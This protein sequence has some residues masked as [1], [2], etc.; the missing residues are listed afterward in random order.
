M[1]LLNLPL[2]LLE[3]TTGYNFRSKQHAQILYD[4]LS[5]HAAYKWNFTDYFRAFPPN[6][7][8][9]WTSSQCRYVEDALNSGWVSVTALAGP[10]NGDSSIPERIS[11]RPPRSATP[12]ENPFPPSHQ[13]PPPIP[14]APNA[15]S[16]QI[17]TQPE[18]PIPTFLAALNRD[19]TSAYDRTITSVTTTL[20]A[21]ASTQQSFLS[22][23]VE[24]L[25]AELASQ[26]SKDHSEISS[27]KVKV[28]AG[29]SHGAREAE[30][31]QARAEGDVAGR[32]RAM[33]EIGDMKEKL[34]REYLEELVRVRRDARM[35]GYEAGFR[36][37]VERRE[38]SHGGI[39][40]TEMG[41]GVARLGSLFS[42]QETKI[43]RQG[44]EYN[45]EAGFGYQGHPGII[46]GR[47]PVSSGENRDPAAEMEDQDLGAGEYNAEFDIQYQPYLGMVE[48]QRPEWSELKHTHDADEELYD[49]TPPRAFKQPKFEKPG[50]MPGSMGAERKVRGTVNNKILHKGPS[51][52]LAQSFTGGLFLS[53]DEEIDDGMRE[54]PLMGVESRFSFY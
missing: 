9:K 16:R 34:Q 35:E 14:T 45:P 52:G 8:S 26:R 10:R 48:E 19:L 25:S 47:R 46:G 29:Q 6:P 11:T 41:N 36:A 32:E 13:P 5:G 51:E 38:M 3:N 17:S 18:E 28:A 37:G 20:L 7:P 22:S 54:L 4:N 12:E 49:A 40:N 50:S 15:N 53:S 33:M 39:E 23:T 1:N 21:S 30:L 2:T 42:E 31:A 24:R 44:E 27:L 43:T